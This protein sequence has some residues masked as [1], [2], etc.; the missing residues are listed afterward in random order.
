ME[1][2]SKRKIIPAL[3]PAKWD[4]RQAVRGRYYLLGSTSGYPNASF[5]KQQLTGK[6][7]P[8]VVLEEEDRSSGYYN[9]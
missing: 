1:S 4:E 5:S 6:E 7:K 8:L 3:P 2:K 9:P